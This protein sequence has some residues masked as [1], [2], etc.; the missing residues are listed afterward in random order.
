MARDVQYPPL[1]IFGPKAIPRLNQIITAI[2]TD[3][4]LKVVVFD[5]V[6]DGFFPTHYDFSGAAR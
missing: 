1:N 3:Q 2:E 4:H 6:I 5:S